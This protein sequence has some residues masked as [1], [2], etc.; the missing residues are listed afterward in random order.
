MDRLYMNYSSNVIYDFNSVAEFARGVAK[1]DQP[2]AS[3]ILDF[4][5][6]KPE[7]DYIN[8]CFAYLRWAD[9]IVDNPS[10]PVN[11][12]KKFI[13]QQKNLI[14]LIYSGNFP[15]PSGI[16]EACLI[17]FAEYAISNGNFI[18]LDEVKNMIDALSMDVDRLENS[19]VFS[20]AELDHYIN[21]MSKSVFNILYNFTLPKSEYR[22]GF[23][24]GSKF[25]TAA[26]MIRDLEEDINAGFI[27]I[28]AEDINRY[29]LDINNLIKDKN[30][31]FC[32]EG[33]IKFIFEI[34]YKEAALLKYLPMK[35][36][37]FT[38]YSLIYRMV[39]V[40]RA[41]IY[42]YNLKYISEQNFINE[43]KTYSLSLLISVNIFLK[44]FIFFHKKKMSIL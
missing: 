5:I 29:K 25:T 43:V 24:L 32:L 38:Y 20:N 4:L 11:Q 17:H 33:R 6:D 39:W 10:L 41:K 26:L 18:L 16:E 40:V 30:F 42:K 15:E 28:P 7:R 21:L 34:L 2:K 27:N 23:Y 14:S 1:N 31:S 36:R 8:I 19:G 13:E 12:K 9:D 35:F 37:I 44:G 22:E 3:K